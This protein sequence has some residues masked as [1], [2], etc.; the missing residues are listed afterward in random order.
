MSKIDWNNEVW[1][2]IDSY[3]KNTPNYLSKHQ[4][5]SYNTFL[6]D[7]IPK[8]IRQFNPIELPYEQLDEDSY[9]F[10]VKITL[11]GE[12]LDGE[13]INSGKGIYIGKPVIQELNTDDESGESYIKQKALFPNEARLKNLTYKTEIKMDIIIEVNVNEEDYEQHAPIFFSQIPLGN[14][15]IMLRSNICSTSLLKSNA[16]RAAG[17]CE[18]DQGGYFIIDG[19]EKVIVAQERQIENKL[20][21]N[22]KP[23]DP[24]YKIIS[25]IRSAPEDKFQ[26]A[27]ITKTV[28]LREKKQRDK[29]IINENTL[30]VIIPQINGEVPLFVVYRAL[31]INSDYDILNTITDVSDRNKYT[32]LVL[33]FLRPSVIEGSIINNTQD[34]IDYLSYKI[35]KTFLKDSSEK[36]RIDFTLEILRNHFIPHAGTNLLDKAFFLSHIVKEIFEVNN[37]LRPSTD[38]DSFLYKR[39]DL[40]GFLIS[41][42]FRDLYFRVKNKMVEVLNV[43]YSK[44]QATGNIDSSTIV[45]YWLEKNA[46]DKYNIVNFIRESNEGILDV[47]N[48]IDRS[49]IDEGFMYAFKN[50][51]GLK[52]APCKEGIVQDINRISYLGFISHL[53]R[54][55]T[56]LS[57]SAKIRAPHSLHGSSW[58][59]MCPSETPDGGNIGVRKNLSTT[60]SIS[61]G[62]NS[63]VLERLLFTSS[64]MDIKQLD[65]N[66]NKATKVLLNER[67]IGYTFEPN[68]LYNKLKIHKRNALINVYTSIAWYKS[69]NIIKLSTDSGRGI[70]PVFIVNNNN[71]NLTTELLA[72]LK[73]PTNNINWNHLV[74]GFKNVST[75]TPFDDTD[76]QYYNI[77]DTELDK[78]EELQ[79]IIEYIDSE[80]SNTSLIALNPVDLESKYDHYDY[81]EI[82]PSLILGVLANNVPALAMNQAP[83]N[84]FSSA[85][86]KQCLGMYATNYRDRFDVK[87]QIMHYPQKAIVK[88][89]Y[90]EYL[91]T[92]VMVHGINAIVA[93]GC[94]SGY[95]QEDSIIFNEDS[96]NRGLFRTAKFRTYAFRDEIEKDNIKEVIEDP[97][98][99]G[100]VLNLKSGNYS[101]LDSNG[102]VKENEKVTENDIIIGK[103]VYTGEKDDN[104]QPVKLD[105][106][107]FIRRAEEGYVDKVYSNLGNDDQRYCK[108]RIRKDKIPELG[109]KFASRHGQ[110]GTVGMLLPSRDLPRT[111]EGLVP[112]MIVNTHAFPSR[113]T[114][115]QFFEL[116]LSKFCVTHGI[117]SQISP[118]A[119][120]DVDVVKNLLMKVGLESNGNEIFYSG[121][122]GEQLHMSFYVGPTYYQRLTHQVSDKYQSRDEGL[123]T[124]LTHQPVGGRAL[125]GGGRIGEMER[126]ALL[127]HGVATFLKESFMERSDGYQFWISTR[128]GL[129]SAVN[130]AKNLYIDLASDA[131]TQ[132]V[133]E[134]GIVEKKYT[135]TS[136]SDFVCIHAPYAF[137]LFLQEVEATS[138][139]L[140][141]VSENIIKKWA[142]Y[143]ENHELIQPIILDGTK[144]R[145][146]FESKVEGYYV[147]TGSY[148]SKPLRHFH[149]KIKSNL[150]NNSLNRKNKSLVDFSVGRAGDMYKWYYLG[151]NKILGIDIEESNIESLSQ[152]VN[153]ANMRLAE[154]KQ[155]DTPQIAEWAKKTDIKF[156][157]GDSSKN[158][159]TDTTMVLSKYSQKL[160]NV[161][162][163]ELNSYGM[164]IMFFAVHYLFTSEEQVKNLFRNVSATVQD[165]GYFLITTLDGN[166]VYNKLKESESG[167]LSAHM[168][169]F[170]DTTRP[171]IKMWSIKMT[172]SLKSK[173]YDNLPSNYQYGFNNNVSVY[174]DSIGSENTESLVHPALLVSIAK[175]MGFELAPYDD[176]LNNFNTEFQYP[177]DSFSN[178]FNSYIKLNPADDTSTSLGEDKNAGLK[179]YTDLHRYF[180][181]KKIKPTEP[182]AFFNTT[183]CRKQLKLTENNR[184]E[185]VKLPFTISLD[186]FQLNSQI[187]IP[188]KLLGNTQSLISKKVSFKELDS[189]LDS[190]QS[191][192]Y[193]ITEK[194]FE[195]TMKYISEY[196]KS[197]IY[198]RIINGSLVSFVPMMSI[199]MSNAYKI[200]KATELEEG[201]ELDD[202]SENMFHVLV[203]NP[204][205]GPETDKIKSYID[206]KHSSPQNLLSGFEKPIF[207]DSNNQNSESDY[208]Y[209]SLGKAS[210]MRLIPQYFG[211]K[212]LFDKLTKERANSLSD[213]ELIINILEHPIVKKTDG[214]FLTNPLKNSTVVID[215]PSNIFPILSSKENSEYD[216]ILNIDYYSF[217]LANK[218]VLP[219][220]TDYCIDTPNII[221]VVQDVNKFGLL[222]NYNG[223]NMEDTVDNL[224]KTILDN[225]IKNSEIDVDYYYINN[226]S[227]EYLP[228]TIYNDK[229]YYQSLSEK[230][231]SLIHDRK[232]ISYDTKI[233]GNMGYMYPNMTKYKAMLYISGYGSDEILTNMVYA[234]KPIIYFRDLSNKFTYWYENM[235]IPYD[236]TQSSKSSYNKTANIIIID[237]DSENITTKWSSCKSNITD[238]IL[239]SISINI[240]ALA[241][242]IFN[243]SNILDYYV[244]LI[245]TLG[246]KLDKNYINTNIKR[247]IFNQQS[248]NYT[249]LRVSQQSIPFI[250]GKGG[251]RIKYIKRISNANISIGN[252]ENSTVKE[253]ITYI[254]IDIT[255]SN[256]DI[257]VAEKMLKKYMNI[258][259]MYMSITNNKMGI[260]IGPKGVNIKKIQNDNDV[261]I[262]TRNIKPEE[263]TGAV[264]E[265]LSITK[266]DYKTNKYTIIKIMSFNNQDISNAISEIKVLIGES[267]ISQ[268][269][270]NWMSDVNF[271]TMSDQLQPDVFGME[272]GQISF[273]DPFGTSEG[274]RTYDVT[275]N[276]PTTT[277]EQYDDD[278]FNDYGNN[279]NIMAN[280]GDID[281]GPDE[282]DYN[283]NKPDSP[284]FPPPS[285]EYSPQSP[286]YSPPSP[287][288]S[289]TE[290]P[291]SPTYSPTEAPPSPHSPDFPP[292]SPAYSPNSPNDQV[293]FVIV[294]PK[295][296]SSQVLFGVGIVNRNTSEFLSNFDT[297]IKELEVDIKR[298]FNEDNYKIITLDEQSM[299]I[300]DELATILESESIE[301]IN[302]SYLLKQNRYDNF[303]ILESLLAKHKYNNLYYL[304]PFTKFDVAK[305]KELNLDT[306]SAAN[307]IILPENSTE[308]T[309]LLMFGVNTKTI[310]D[311]KKINTLSNY[312]DFISQQHI[313]PK[314]D[315]TFELSKSLVIT[316]HNNVPYSEFI[317]KNNSVSDLVT[318]DFDFNKNIKNMNNKYLVTTSINYT[319][320]NVYNYQYCN[321][322]QNLKV[323]KTSIIAKYKTTENTEKYKYLLDTFNRILSVNYDSN[324]N[325]LG[326]LKVNIENEIIDLIYKDITE[327]CDGL[328]TQIST[329][330]SENII[331]L[332]NFDDKYISLF[333]TSFITKAD[334]SKVFKNLDNIK[335][336][337]EDYTDIIKNKP[338]LLGDLFIYNP[339]YVKNYTNSNNVIIT[340]LDNKY[341]IDD[342]DRDMYYNWFDDSKY[343]GYKN[344]I[345]GNIA[346][347]F[348]EFENELQYLDI[349]KESQVN[350]YDLDE[351]YTK[352]NKIEL[353]RKLYWEYIIID[354]PILKQDKDKYTL[355]ADGIRI[356][357]TVMTSD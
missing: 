2:V 261:K 76:S 314:S 297:Y 90:V 134:N 241:D 114:I 291:P 252:I 79:G 45:N 348:N 113:M 202:D 219:V 284:D 256:T 93:I 118:F 236:W 147:S 126:D 347:V 77:D 332:V 63:K 39:V 41:S 298:Y 54:I 73:D 355:D 36:E 84:Q 344:I 197:A 174:V 136:T 310:H 74:G 150:M 167:E 80:E 27:R 106:S 335:S 268:Q 23:K 59:I 26:P 82:S 50:C 253:G 349:H 157:V 6:K 299:S 69:E 127:S 71:I 146:L 24:R 317:S 138:I 295:N 14:I 53:R 105:N 230:Q 282:F 296:T 101:K 30:R 319:N 182:D 217:A 184:Y 226:I 11:G 55:N 270:N 307:L 321:T 58:G 232:A 254:P 62:T 92:D 132:F 25:E 87:G 210:I 177:T 289:P 302:G 70:R 251:S 290:A 212:A 148:L 273:D 357:T 42:I 158:M 305:F 350:L 223:C 207:N 272:P 315:N 247:G 195:N 112:D 121:I 35:S 171:T 179:E 316:S 12:L 243:T 186:K 65:P 16:L 257:L 185:D 139:A 275:S 334:E 352:L 131:S 311:I 263:L 91:N 152:D 10:D 47:K 143:D 115:A 161:K 168:T 301:Y 343:S 187:N 281:L 32:K 189:K 258:Q 267:Q 337:I 61:F 66:K 86:G 331:L 64:V 81:C 119:E 278:V 88:S 140:R 194:S 231:I 276:L 260:L 122:T 306:K 193:D 164:G 220:D 151:L 135:N 203:F 129:I 218:L 209:I 124:S 308:S 225:F 29:V 120:I 172:D 279:S 249:K 40:S 95:N 330:E 15:P 192:I 142:K 108:V 31:G 237:A 83:R 123:K 325:I 293:D 354:E 233:P 111:K 48:I 169:D 266:D 285:P 100:N 313:K 271:G 196:T 228:N 51:W 201:E 125:G 19:K 288:Y 160:D 104:M 216:D 264:F 89:R 286:E 244:T 156:L 183:S 208:C 239:E 340:L 166:L 338:K 57:S 13:V 283:R 287:T 56:P 341:D 191:K 3:F 28:L 149:N 324:I 37:N 94:F 346:I 238:D 116:L 259:S 181:F 102:I 222:F 109:D 322:Y 85:H 235:F 128:T 234:K 303:N 20:Y 339:Y 327:L 292:P 248:T 277:S 5:D 17:E 200:Q 34:A 78:Y 215:I 18:Y 141:L 99:S 43:A 22:L 204:N 214:P 274:F 312:E 9:K 154:M 280:Y 323:N 137:K 38:R 60:A 8:T 49:I 163:S 351:D 353:M 229:I 1:N 107:E 103:V 153:S 4:I 333:S 170:K 245:N 265:T 326:K 336:E 356:K 175:E 98:S 342:T 246:V 21:T 75:K 130:P 159:I 205:A 269:V 304:E 242:K 320:K 198:L 188:R 206:A 173:G 96:V 72:K 345:I 7:N 255:G 68:F 117:N 227:M 144:F 329:N 250:I 211:Y 33:D 162:Q 294:V 52:D 110:K 300:S 165:G 67:L 213:C 46:N 309:P 221:D 240:S 318:N 224:R 199:E 97:I 180:I 145:E 178:V 262:Y 190:L 155:H 328:N 133:N 44:A 176:M